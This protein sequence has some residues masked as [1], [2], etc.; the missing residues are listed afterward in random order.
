MRRFT[1]LLIFFCLAVPVAFA[2]KPDKAQIE[3]DVRAAMAQAGFRH[4]SL[5]VEAELKTIGVKPNMSGKYSLLWKSAQDWLE[6]IDAGAYSELAMAKGEHKLHKSNSASPSFWTVLTR[7]AFDPQNSW[8]NGSEWKL[9]SV[10]P[11]KLD[12][13][14]AECAAFTHG[15]QS[16]LEACIDVET[17]DLLWLRH[18]TITRY[19]KFELL[20][21]CRYPRH[22]EV[23]DRITGAPY[24]VA[25]IKTLAA[26]AAVPDAPAGMD[27][28]P[29]CTSTELTGG[30]LEAKVAPG[31]P[32]AARANRISGT[33][34]LI[35]EI[36]TDGNVKVNGVAGSV[37]PLLDNSA[38]AAVSRW[39]YSPTMCHGVAIPTVDTVTV[40]F[41]LSR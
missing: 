26:D 30:L 4:Q 12:G 32:E 2:S 3:A 22:V 16:R 37:H 9:D 34:G 5:T 14:R 24:L 8:H 6:R 41:A 28:Q 33:V 23:G 21:D 10:R 15:A 38:V 35:A 13:V 31:Y 7:H 17:K 11:E 1:V 18:G 40:N 39:K 27:A 25:E 29:N 36:Q 20:H 19:S